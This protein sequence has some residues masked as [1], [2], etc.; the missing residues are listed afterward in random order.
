MAGPS[1]VPF[2]TVGEWAFRSGRQYAN[3]F[4]DVT[5]D[6]VFTSPSGK[7][8]TQPAFHDGDGVWKVRFNPAEAGLWRYEL[9]SRPLDRELAGA[10][11][12]EVSGEQPRGFLKATPGE[13]WGFRYESGEPANC[14]TFS[15]DDV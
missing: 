5:V 4:A 13:A 7:T 2:R 12:F 10:G 11:S 14:D 3:A 15:P 8:L 6:A 1:R 9:T